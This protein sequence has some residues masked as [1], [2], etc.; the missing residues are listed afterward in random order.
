ML[1]VIFAATH[2]SQSGLGEAPLTSSLAKSSQRFVS[3][4]RGEEDRKETLASPFAQVQAD[5]SYWSPRLEIG[6]HMRSADLPA[7]CD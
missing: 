6:A 1:F 5:L 2:A 3:G 4:N 7:G